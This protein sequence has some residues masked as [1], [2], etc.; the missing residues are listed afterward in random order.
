MTGGSAIQGLRHP[1][2]WLAWC[3]LIGLFAPAAQASG[4]PDKPIEFTVPFAVGGGSD[5]MARVI[6]AIVERDN[7]L[8]QPVVVVNRPGANGILGYL[9]VGLKSGNPYVVSAATPSFV[10]Q[11]LLGRMQLTHRDY[12]P[13][14]GLAL[15]EFVLVVRTASPHHTV[16]D[17][18]TAARRVPKGVAVGGSSTPSSD[19]IMAHLLERATGVRLNY[20]PFKGG[21]EVMT[22]LLGG[23]IDVASAN[24]AEVLDHVQA[25]QIRVLAAASER[26]LASLPQVPTLRES[27]IDV[28]VTQWRGVVAPKGLPPE[29][30]TALVTA[31]KRV[32]ESKAWERYLR[33]NNLTPLY[34]SPEA[35]SRYLDAEAEKML[36][37]LG[38]M[39]LLQ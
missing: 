3:V 1:R 37:I 35:F 22:N 29:A 28:V 30:Q 32:S 11:P 27:G 39:G 18:I 9:H 16:G 2:L 36:R 24:P 20:V 7:L 33:E 21:G 23:H 4:Y 25:G 8:P 12:T 26:R 14:A 6:A 10:I 34:L 38:E 5:I 17:L 31:F 13:I 15:D 19:S